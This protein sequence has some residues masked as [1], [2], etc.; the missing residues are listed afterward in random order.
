RRTGTPI[1]L[2]FSAQPEREE[3]A[4]AIGWRAIHHSANVTRNKTASVSIAFHLHAPANPIK[5]PDRQKRKRRRR[6]L[7]SSTI[8]AVKATKLHVRKTIRNASIIP[9]RDPR[10]LSLRWTEV[11]S[12]EEVSPDSHENSDSGPVGRLALPERSSLR[13]KTSLPAS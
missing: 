4:F 6:I 12:P 5:T 8:D 10:R 9:M 11:I 2:V 3:L 7:T 1:C 13:H